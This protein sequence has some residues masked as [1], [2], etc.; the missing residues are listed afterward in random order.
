MVVDCPCGEISERKVQMLQ[1]MPALVAFQASATAKS[2]LFDALSAL[3]LCM[4]NISK[5]EKNI[6]S[7]CLQL[8]SY[9][10]K[11]IEHSS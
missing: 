4:S 11:Q 1:C 10:A 9:L 3:L 6:N 7:S 2:Q 8:K 5:L